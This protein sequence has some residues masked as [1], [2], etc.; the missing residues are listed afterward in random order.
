ME[1]NGLVLSL[2]F[3]RTHHYKGHWHLNVQ[4]Y[5]HNGGVGI[6]VTPLKSVG[7]A[8]YM[9]NNVAGV[10]VPD[11]YIERLQSSSDPKEEGIKIC[12]EQIQQFKEMDGI[13]GVHLMAIEWEQ[14]V[15]E[16]VERAGLLPRPEVDK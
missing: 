16:I 14:M 6:S 3:E 13:A 1:S 8:N 5:E 9:K 11:E 7:M 12:V 10:T 2:P 4:W 15:P